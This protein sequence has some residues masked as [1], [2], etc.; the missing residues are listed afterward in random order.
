MT[1]TAVA[2]LALAAALLALPAAAARPP[3]L[4]VFAR[5]V[6]RAGAQ[7]E[8]FTVRPDGSGVRRLTFDPG[9]EPDPAW[10]RDGRRLAALGADGVI[11]RAE[12]GRV[13]SRI[14]MHAPAGAYEL[15]W[16]P[17]G[18]WISYLAERCQDPNDPRSG[19]TTPGC[20]D[21]WVVRP[22]PPGERRLV[23]ADVD[24]SD[25]EASYSWAPGGERIVYE[26]QTSGATRLAVVD[27]ETG[28]QRGRIPGTAGSADPVW[29]PRAPI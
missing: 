4:I 21:L 14:A 22:D 10:S 6:D 26:L 24:T 20:A 25:L 9:Y 18:R 17:T 8:L 16:S 1:R 5:A 7:L 19:Y 13:Q 3:S 23:D 11:V 28:R 2:V 12:D 29:S 15:D 27:V